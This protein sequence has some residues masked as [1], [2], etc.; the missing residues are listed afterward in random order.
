MRGYFDELRVW[1]VARAALDIKGSYDKSLTGGE[2]GLVGC[3]S[4]NPSCVEIG[5]RIR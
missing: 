3:L 1:N 4:L 5:E 2:A